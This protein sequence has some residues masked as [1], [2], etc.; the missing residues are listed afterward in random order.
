MFKKQDLII[1]SAALF[2]ALACFLI[3]QITHSE[4]GTTV[5]ITV[6]GTEYAIM[7]LNTN[8]T[9]TFTT[10]S[11]GKFTVQIENGHVSV[12][13]SD[14]PNQICVKHSAISRS[15]ECIVCIPNRAVIEIQGSDAT[16]P[17]A[18]AR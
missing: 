3:R 15:G 16:A 6:D 1:L 8:R 5:R 12:P 9:E 17:D 4:S 7:E 10:P 18:I 2:L 13:F 11:G 14:C